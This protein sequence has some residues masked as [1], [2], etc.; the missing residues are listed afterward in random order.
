MRWA[1]SL[2][3]L[4]LMMA[5]FH[6]VTA[7]SPLEA[8]AALALGFLLVAAWLG[9][10]I[11][12][13]AHVPRVTAFVLSGLFLGPAWLNVVRADEV[14]DAALD[15]RP[16]A[17]LLFRVRAG[18]C[19]LIET[20]H[21]FDRNDDAHAGVGVGHAAPNTVRTVLTTSVRSDPSSRR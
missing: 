8:R 2:V 20:A 5:A 4:G 11:A 13:R 15:G 3:V 17:G 19:S 1:V 18:R 10:A 6:R 12:R 16:D 21:V 9:S 14:D 7:A